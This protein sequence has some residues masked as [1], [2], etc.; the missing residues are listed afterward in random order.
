M[1]NNCDICIKLRDELSE[2][3]RAY[4]WHSI[5][6]CKSERWGDCYGCINRSNGIKEKQKEIENHNLIHNKNKLS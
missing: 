1:D 3:K 2:L 4:D 5:N 6:V